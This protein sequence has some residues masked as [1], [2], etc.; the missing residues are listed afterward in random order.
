MFIKG[1]IYVSLR[2]R[3]CGDHFQSGQLTNEAIYQIV[4]FKSELISFNSYEIQ[5]I[6]TDFRALIQNQEAFDLDND[7]SLDDT[8]YYNITGLLKS[9]IYH[10]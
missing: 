10:E 4:P 1:G 8:A 9:V 2:A 6:I 3:C 5:K 7:A